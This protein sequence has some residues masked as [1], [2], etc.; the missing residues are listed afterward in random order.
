MSIIEKAKAY[1]E[2]KAL[3]AMTAAIEDAY[4]A[5]FKD[6]YDEGLKSRDN[7]LANEVEDGVEYIDLGLPNGTK[8]SIDFLRDENGRVKLFY[9]DEARNY[10]LPTCQQYLDFIN[11]TRREHYENYQRKKFIKILG[12]NGNRIQWEKIMSNIAEFSTSKFNFM[13]WL[14]NIQENGSTRIAAKDSK[15]VDIF[16]GYKLPIILVR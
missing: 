1:A 9:Y 3:N 5:G 13:F 4:A 8:W 15:M 11:N 10:N 7:L 6:G 14:K 2:G 12:A 16:T